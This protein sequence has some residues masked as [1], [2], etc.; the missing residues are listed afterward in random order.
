[1]IDLLAAAAAFT[2]VVAFALAALALLT[3]VPFVLAL[4]RAE[5]RGFD[6]ARWGAVAL[7]GSV[8]GVG[9]ALVALRSSLVLLLLAVPLAFAGLLALSVLP[10]DSGIGGRAGRH[11]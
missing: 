2:A 3:L 7:V 8:L 9:L 1:M 5:R 11:Q 6:P 10:A 4:R